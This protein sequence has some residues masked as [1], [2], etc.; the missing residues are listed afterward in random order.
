MLGQSKL[1]DLLGVILAAF[2]I[3]GCSG[4]TT[5]P[6]NEQPDVEVAQPTAESV[7]VKPEEPSDFASDNM[8]AIDPMGRPISRTFYF[9]YDQAVLK[10]AD[11]SALEMHAGILRR[12]RDRSIV[13]E[14]HCDERGTREYN[15][16]LGEGRATA[17]S[18]FLISAGV[19]AG[20]IELVSYGEER[21]EDPGHNESAWSR[22]RRAIV[23]YQ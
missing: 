18:N 6:V 20:Q 14:G 22:N 2:V 1:R 23:S 4:T 5:E 3:T 9:D 7:D 17:V 16:A 11:L 15:L 10:P 12:N 8:T 19:R 13:I 21:P